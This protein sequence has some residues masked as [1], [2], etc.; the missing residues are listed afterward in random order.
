MKHLRLFPSMSSSKS[1]I[2][3][4]REHCSLHRAPPLGM[5]VGVLKGRHGT[6][7]ECFQEN[8]GGS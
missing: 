2:L 8:T 6:M 5:A 4:F 3:R 1:K 7:A